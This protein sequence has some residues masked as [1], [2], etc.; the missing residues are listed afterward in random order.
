MTWW[1]LKRKIFSRLN[2]PSNIT[3]TTPLNPSEDP[4]TIPLLAQAS[5]FSGNVSPVV[6]TGFKPSGSFVDDVLAIIGGGGL[7]IRGVRS[8]AKAA[9]SNSVAA[10]MPDPKNGMNNANFKN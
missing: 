1:W 5:W 10:I 8:W 2:E 6:T 3:A 4:P 7:Y 9:L